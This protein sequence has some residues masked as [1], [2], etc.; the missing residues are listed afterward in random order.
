MTSPG[1]TAGQLPANTAGST[2]QIKDHMIHIDWCNTKYYWVWIPRVLKT[3]ESDTGFEEVKENVD[4]LP[5]KTRFM[6]IDVQRNYQP[7]PI[8]AQ[9]TPRLISGSS[10]IHLRATTHMVIS[11]LHHRLKFHCGYCILSVFNSRELMRGKRT[12]FTSKIELSK[13]KFDRIDRF[14]TFELREHSSLAKYASWVLDVQ[15]VFIDAVHSGTWSFYD[16]RRSTIRVLPGTSFSSSWTWIAQVESKT[17]EG[18]QHKEEIVFQLL[19]LSR[20]IQHDY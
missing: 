16:Y 12:S 1:N 7:V 14:F 19:Y 11:S 8:V 13:G 5:S 2:L 6:K 4:R 3:A 9:R 17:V 10:Y 15:H 20:A 18:I